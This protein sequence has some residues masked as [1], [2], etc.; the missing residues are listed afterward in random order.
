MAFGRGHDRFA[1]RIDHANGTIEQPGGDCD[2][3][4]NGQIELRAKSAA[5]R[6]RD[7]PHLLGRDAQDL[8]HVV[9]IHIGR[10]RAGLDLDAV[11]DTAS[12]ARL[13]LDVGVLDETCLESAFDHDIRRSEACNDIATRHAS[14]RQDVVSAVRMNAFGARIERL[15]ERRERGPRAPGYRKR[16]KVEIAH[17]FA[18]ADHQRD[19]LAA[20]AREA[21]RQRRLVRESRDHAIA[22]R[23]R[24]HPWR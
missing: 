20:K 9:A 5:D 1:A 16:R 2:E 4:L 23:C 21:L 22:V 12:K 19:G 24:G 11:A 6:R 8:R 15:F 7:D 3:R 10:L 14:G 13:R 17:R 18:V